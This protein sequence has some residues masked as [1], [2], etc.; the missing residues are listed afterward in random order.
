[1]PAWCWCRFCCRVSAGRCTGLWIAAIAIQYSASFLSGG[2]G[3]TVAREVAASSIHD[4]SNFVEAVSNAYFL[5]GIVGAMVI[6]AAGLALASGLHISPDNISTARLIFGL[7]GIGLLSDQVQAVAMDILLGLRR[8]MIIN[9]ITSLSVLVRFAGI[10]IVLKAGGTIVA[11]AAWHVAI[12]AATAATAYTVALRH[13]PQFRPRLQRIR[14][15]EMRGQLEFSLGS[16]IIAGCNI[17]LWRSAPFLIGLLRGAAAIVP[18]ELGQKFPISV[19]S[20]S[21]QAADVLFPAASEYHSA[22][23]HEHTRQLLEVG[24]RGVLLFTLPF[25]IVLWILA[26]T[27]LATW[28]GGRSSDV[29]WILRFITVAVLADSLAAGSLQVVWGQ[30]RM[31]WASSLALISTIIGVIA[32]ACLIV[33]L[34]PLGAAIGLTVGVFV[35][36]AG[37]IFF[38]GRL[39]ACNPAQILMSAVKDLVLPGLEHFSHRCTP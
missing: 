31:K 39:C 5:I 24:T 36:S 4:S 37:F 28:V 22:Q 27:L 33:R 9:T 14:W 30:G 10:V 15:S 13:A 23:Q 6:D 20:I 38:A 1:M 26:P 16:Q 12:C 35:S 34:G 3:R 29:I 21:W 19:S 7:T 18:Y 11:L 8:F 2:L 17:V 32:A 25:C